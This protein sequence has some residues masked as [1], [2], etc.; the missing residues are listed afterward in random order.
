MADALI[1]EFDDVTR[2]HYDAVNAALGLNPQ[3]GEGDWPPA[4]RFHSG[5][6]KPG[7]WVVFEVW[8]SQAAQEE[9]MHGRLGAALQEVGV[10]PPAR[11]EW[12]DVAAHLTT[13]T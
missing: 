11:V 4:L 3:T 2:E 13:G 8:E 7:G 9:W 5:A 10:P 12:L 6:G 1:L